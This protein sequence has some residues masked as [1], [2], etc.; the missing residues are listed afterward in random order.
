M[1]IRNAEKASGGLC[2]S[3]EDADVEYNFEIAKVPREKTAE[4]FA[5]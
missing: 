3:K 5:K 1:H 2:V 4:V